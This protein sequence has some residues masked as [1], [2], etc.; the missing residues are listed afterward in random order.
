MSAAA[1]NQNASIHMRAEK[2]KVGQ[3]VYQFIK[4]NPNE[5]VYKT[6]DQEGYESLKPSEK[7]RAVG[8]R[9]DG[10][11]EYMLFSAKYAEQAALMQDMSPQKMSALG[12]LFA[13]ANRLRSKTF[14]SL[15]PE[16]FVVN[17]ARDIQAG[18]INLV[19]EH[20]LSDKDSRQMIANTMKESTKN[21]RYML[22]S[23][24]PSVRE[25]L[26]TS[27]PEYFQFLEEFKEDGGVTGWGY[28]PNIEALA[29]ELDKAASEGDKSKM[30][31]SWMV[32]NGADV[33]TTMSDAF[34]NSIRLSTYV[35]ARKMGMS[36]DRA[37]FLSKEVTVNFNRSGEWGP[38]MNS[39]YMFFNASVQGSRRLVNSMNSSNGRKIGTGMAL[40][41][42]MMTEYNRSISGEDEDGVLYYDKISPYDRA[43]NIII[44]REDGKNF[45]KIPLPYGYG[46]FHN[47]GEQVSSVAHGGRTAGE[48][49]FEMADAS[50]S[51]FSPVT[52]G[53]SDNMITKA[54]KTFTPSLALPMVEL[55]VNEDWMGNRIYFDYEGKAK[56]EQA[57]D[58][59]EFMKDFFQGLNK[60]TG[61]TEISGGSEFYSIDIN[62]DKITHGISAYAGGIG[63]T[64]YKTGE[65]IKSLAEGETP[66]IGRFPILSKFYGRSDYAELSDYFT[67][68]DNLDLAETRIKEYKDEDIRK[69]F[70]GEGRFRGIG[71]LESN[72]KR[73]KSGINDLEEKLEL[74]KASGNT[75]E[76]ERI[77]GLINRNMKMFNKAFNLFIEGT[78]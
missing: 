35:N 3:T 77:E 45:V 36:R 58:S 9:I 41:G 67:Y 65:T 1:L 18:F 19:S 47:I 11:T 24:V 53:S 10:K 15:N 57:Y 70:E 66:D 21:L 48:A 23:M 13:S 50:I 60:M 37:A 43:R 16:F 31:L 25:K 39:A 72:M 51:A 54:G 33:L 8:V 44:M 73:S 34:E 62:P 29:K 4:D 59:P 56:S 26:K 30:S 2:N 22:G 27:D 52:F 38:A 76:V 63:Q 20:G 68:R 69:R 55:M 42:G 17:F 14:T 71:A 49:S 61:G 75:K 12:K 64:F 40:V 78:E 46:L 28:A 74:A 5:E 32:E 6:V 7:K